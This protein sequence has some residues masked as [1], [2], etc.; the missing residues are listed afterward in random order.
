MSKPIV[1]QPPSK[2][3]RLG[4]RLPIWLYRLNLGWLLGNRFLMLTHTGR[5]SG[6]ARQ[7]LIEVVQHDKESDAFYV[8]SGWAEKSNWYQNIQKTP[9]VTVRV[10]R[11]EFKANA[12][13]IPLIEE[14]KIMEGYA[15]EHPTAFKELTSL[16]L[17]ERMKADSAS[18]RRVAE[19]M[20]MV[21]F[22]PEGTKI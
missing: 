19:K 15:H 13:F 20:P 3:L 9:R 10:G 2:M 4:L 14:I 18:V 1:D 21:A 12:K 8:V 5:K 22:Y 7:T 6:L 17:G 16:F 11:R